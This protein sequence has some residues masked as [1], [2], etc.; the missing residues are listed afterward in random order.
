MNEENMKPSMEL[1]FY[2]GNAKSMAMQSITLAEEGNLTEAKKMLAEANTE[3]HKSHKL[4][5][6]MMQSELQGEMIEKSILLIHAQ[7]H[8]MG[9]T[10]NC[11]MAEK[12]IHL[13]E[14]MR[15]E[16]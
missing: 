12:F 4:Q 10:L 3:L 1:I 5:T 8:F 9:A 14:V 13:Y 6:E 16:I 7:D 2:A 11:E 15:K